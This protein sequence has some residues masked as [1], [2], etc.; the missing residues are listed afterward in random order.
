MNNLKNEYRSNGNVS[1]KIVFINLGS[2]GSTGNI[3]KTLNKKATEKGFECFNI[4]PVDDSVDYRMNNILLGT[5]FSRRM[6]W[7]MSV[8]TGL[9]GCF[10]VFSTIKAIRKLKELKPDIIHFHNLHYSYINIPLL[11]NYVKKDNIPVIWTLHDCW[12]FTGHCP[13]FIYE[14]CDKW[15]TGCFHC[16]RYT[17]YPRSL[18]DNSKFMWKLKRKWFANINEMVIVTPSKWLKNQVEQSFLKDYSI[19]VINNGIN[20]SVFN[21]SKSDFR[22]KYNI[23]AQYIVLGVANGWGKQKGIDVFVNLAK[24]LD[25]SFQIVLVGTN[26]EIDKQLP[27]N[28]ISIH[29]TQNQKELAEIYTA[30]DVFANP[31][32]EDTFPTVNM[33]SLACG[34]PVITFDTGGSPEIIDVTC[35]IVTKEKTAE[36]M[37]EAIKNVCENKLFSAENCIERAKR[38]GNEKFIEEYMNLYQ[39]NI[40]E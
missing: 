3:M 19:K 34:T 18:Y 16:P 9:D 13:H 2:F 6:S 30:A 4:V 15:K 40:K 31:T 29:R 23:E 20:L 22:T 7:R 28:I 10:S 5:K 32:R 27:K 37:A 21:P 14:K 11:I 36:S 35:G 24:M 38:F 1:K 8:A 26:D 33:E 25:D 39:E 17:S 12:S